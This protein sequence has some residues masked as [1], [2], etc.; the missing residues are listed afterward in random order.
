MQ[1]FATHF[2]VWRELRS[3]TDF[4]V[5]NARVAT[6][7]AVSTH[8]IEGFATGSDAMPGGGAAI[9][10]AAR[11]DLVAHP[12]ATAHI[13]DFTDAVG[14]AAGNDPL[15][16][17]RA[18][19]VRAALAGGGVGR[20]ALHAAGSGATAFVAANDSDANRRRNRRVVITIEE[21]AS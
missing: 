3:G 9:A 10:A 12:Q 7:N 20:G 14:N 6:R 16:R 5:A 17:R 4:P 19:T 21:P 15:S 18:A 13:I 8:T 1:D 2:L 11:A